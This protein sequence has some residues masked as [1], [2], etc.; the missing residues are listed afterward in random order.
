MLKDNMAK[1]SKEILSKFV[2]EGFFDNPKSVDEV[3][4]K[5]DTRGFSIK[6]DKK[7][8]IA[9]LLTFLCQDGILE[10]EKNSEGKWRYKKLNG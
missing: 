3:C 10:R 5:L 4:D 9:Q 2:Q 1:I 8:L 6:A 7:G